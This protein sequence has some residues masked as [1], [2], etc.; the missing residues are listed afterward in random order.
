MSVSRVW[1]LRGLSQDIVRLACFF[2]AGGYGYLC[3]KSVVTES[4][5]WLKF[6]KDLYNRILSGKYSIGEISFAPTLTRVQL[7]KLR[8]VISEQEEVFLK[9]LSGKDCNITL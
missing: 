6:I 3:N 5:E 1:M 2:R 8:K 4:E 7:F 9:E